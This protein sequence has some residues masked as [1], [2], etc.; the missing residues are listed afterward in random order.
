EG[1]TMIDYSADEITTAESEKIIEEVKAR[2]ES[3]QLKF[4]PGFGFRHL[5]VWK[6]GPA[7]GKLTPPHDISGRVIG[8]YLPKGQGG[9]ILLRLM[10]ESAGFLPAHPV[11][12][13]RA[14][15][16]LRPANAIWFWG[17]GKR[18]RMPKFY[19]RYRL[20]GSIIS[21]VDLI[22]GIGIYAGF[23]IVE[24][25]GAT[26]TVNTNAEGK[27]RAALAE[28]GKGQDLVYLHVEAPDA[29]SHRGELD[30]KIK[31]IE[32]VDRILGRLLHEL[33]IYDSYKIMVLPDHP[34]P[35][36]TM[37][38]SRNPVPFAIYSKGQTKKI[39]RA[40]DE[41]TASRGLVIKDGHELMDYF[42]HS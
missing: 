20:N 23:N 3:A 39:N 12:A 24:V 27:V 25:E 17:M 37:T 34:T 35:L 11:N 22:K 4:Y 31:A 2:L 19:D 32:M 9:D 40:Y 14:G 7:G 36:A 16:G 15:K 28:L 30:T 42:L 6:G 41:P 33:D 1:K 26:G 5:L 29:A 10:R 18:P 21:A 8:P 38:H 13:A